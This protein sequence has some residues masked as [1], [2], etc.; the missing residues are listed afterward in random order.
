MTAT[1]P[2]TSAPSIVE[3]IEGNYGSIECAFYAGFSNVAYTAAAGSLYTGNG[4]VALGLAG[5]GFAAEYTA[6]VQGC[7]APPEPLE[8]NGM[9]C[10]GVDSCEPI[11]A[12]LP[13][14]DAGIN[15]GAPFGKEIL[16]VTP[17][18]PSPNNPN[19]NRPTIAYK[20]C[21]GVSLTYRPNA[22]LPV[23]YR[24]GFF[25]GN[26]NKTGTGG[27]IHNPGD[28]IGDPTTHTDPDG[29]VWSIT[30]TDSYVDDSGVFHV[31][32]S[33]V[34][35]D[36]ACG[37]PFGY[38]SDGSGPTFVNPEFEDPDG[39]PPP[40]PGV[41]PRD[42][43]P[44]GCPCDHIDAK[45]AEQTTQ[46]NSIT[47]DL[48]SIS[49]TVNQIK[50]DLPP[51]PE[52][53]DDNW[54]EKLDILYLLINAFYEETVPPSEL[55]IHGVCEPVN[56]DDPQQ[57]STTVILPTEPKSDRIISSIDALADLL[58]AHLGYRTPTCNGPQPDPPAEGELVTLR[59]KSTENSP[60][61]NTPIRKLLRYR[62]QSGAELGAITQYW[63]G[64]TWT[65]GPAI[66]THR[67]ATWG[68]V[69]VW[70]VTADEGKRVI[71]HAGGEAGIDPDQVGRWEISSSRNPR[72]GVSL[73]V[74]L[75]NIDNGPWITQRDGPSGPPQIAR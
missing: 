32:Y 2:L 38:W 21:N 20:D 29:C 1:Q 69:Q 50:D 40:P 28:P 19:L 55:S 8:D 66:V 3:Y 65:A 70:A 57:P 6:A 37:G 48:S 26:C 22:N 31:Y 68:V 12:S 4:A 63:A 25:S 51:A 52:P 43:S 60:F 45:F 46:L 9:M 36:P 18:E 54:W 67:G 58:Q 62:S 34:A 39:G 72:Y 44:G 49:N 41:E 33:V 42:D 27:D 47:N 61:S 15:V 23:E 59:F 7:N 5:L 11:L 56:P 64:F 75:E 35:N 74:S 13:P 71:R 53:G 16:S 73:P 10:W 17:G 24:W 30:P 14:Y